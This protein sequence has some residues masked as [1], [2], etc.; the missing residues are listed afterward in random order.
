MSHQNEKLFFLKVII[1]YIVLDHPMSICF[2][3]GS[4]S[5]SMTESNMLVIEWWYFIFPVWGLC[6]SLFA[7][8]EPQDSLALSHWRE[9]LCVWTWRLQQGLLQRLRPSQAPEP[10]TFKWGTDKIIPLINV[11]FSPWA[12]II[13]LLFFFLLFFRNPTSAK[14]QAAPNATQTPARSVS[15]SRRFTGLKRTSPRS[16][17]E[18]TRALL[19]HPA[20]REPTAKDGRPGN[21]PWEATRTKG[22]TTMLPR[23]RM[24]VC[25]SSPSRLRSPWYDSFPA[26]F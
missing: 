12:H 19:H 25:R 1:L 21:Y 13:L 11:M 22:S 18:I 2:R 23:N 20:S 15:M 9:A 3:D 4:V 6:Q 10:H 14:S 7:T 16:S 5:L 24:N 8:G 17:V 26:W